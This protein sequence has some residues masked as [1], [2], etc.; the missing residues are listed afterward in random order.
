MAKAE[1]DDEL[2]WADPVEDIDEPIVDDIDTNKTAEEAADE[3]T[4]LNVNQQR[5]PPWDSRYWLNHSTKKLS[6]LIEMPLN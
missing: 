6:K 5:I 4:L 3:W 2:V 1:K